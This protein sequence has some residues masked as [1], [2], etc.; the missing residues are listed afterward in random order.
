M[1]SVTCCV[2]VLLGDRVYTGFYHRQ[3]FTAFDIVRK[4]L[5]TCWRKT[6]RK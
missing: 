2:G 5:N 6:K 4:L 3:A 1:F